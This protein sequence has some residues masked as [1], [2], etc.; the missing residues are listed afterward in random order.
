MK[1]LSKPEKKLARELMDKGLEAEFEAGIKE[2]EA[3]IAKWKNKEL[4]N[5]EAYHAIHGSMRDHRKH[6][7]LRYDGVTGSHYLET[8]SY[9]LADGFLTADDIAGFSDENRA[10]LKRYLPENRK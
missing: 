1:E 3:V 10:Y 7:A 9:I 4:T 2:A 5:R 6:L 8:V